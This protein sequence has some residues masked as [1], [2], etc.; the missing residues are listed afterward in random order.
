MCGRACSSRSAP[1]LR[2]RRGAPTQKGGQQCGRH[3]VAH[4]I[5][6]RQ[7]HDVAVDDVVEGVTADM[8]HRFEGTCDGELGRFDG[9]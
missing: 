1:S 6:D 5:G 2:A 9:Q 8:G 7:P 3:V 4:G